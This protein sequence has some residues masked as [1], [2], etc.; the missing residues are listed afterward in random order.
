MSLL[1]RLLAFV[2]LTWMQ[3]MGA[4]LGW[5]VWWASPGYRRQFRQ[6]VQWAGVDAQQARAA[7]GA[8]GRMVAELPWV[9][10][11]PASQSLSLR[12]DWHGRERIQAALDRGQGLVILSPHLGSWEVGAQALAEAFGRHQNWV[13][14]FRPPRK[15]WLQ[16]L[17]QRSR[18]RDKVQGVPTS[19]S[20][21]R[22][23]VRALKH[24]AGTAI[25]PD[26]VP[27]Q[28][29]GVWAPFWGRPAYTMTLL[30]RLL[31]QTGATVL[32]CW[33]ERLK[34]GRFALHVHPCSTLDLA[35]Q[36]GEA[37]HRRQLADLIQLT[38]AMNADIESLVRAHP[39][40]YLWGYDRH[41]Q[42]RKEA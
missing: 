11:R 35:L 33:C 6:Q 27:P 19:L 3:A 39:Q 28:G 2:P 7:I 8:A 9:W 12:L 41:K 37:P 40:Q 32:L 31:E 26:Q 42:P 10:A 21:V 34:G 20:G 29:M 16:K 5:L 25:L 15:P 13:V 18:Q 1:F 36:R 22:I 38:T 14:L 4:A 30:P 24:G 17:V 23:L